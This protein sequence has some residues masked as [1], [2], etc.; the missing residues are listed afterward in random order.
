[1]GTRLV[2]IATAMTATAMLAACTSSEP[3]DVETVAAPTVAPATVSAGSAAAVWRP[4]TGGAPD[5]RTSTVDVLVTRVS[6][7]SGVTG[8]VVAPSIQEAGDRVVV[9]F[10]VTPEVEVGTC[11][12]NDWVPYRID[13][14]EPLGGRRLV[15]GR[16]LRGGDRDLTR[17]CESLRGVGDPSR[18]EVLRNPAPS[19]RTKR[20]P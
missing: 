10:E 12:S 8:D 13:L 3:R 16:C 4:A 18:D 14:G 6:C 19:G 9:T 20:A 7:S 5:P 15:D 17:V 2:W 11:P 1:M